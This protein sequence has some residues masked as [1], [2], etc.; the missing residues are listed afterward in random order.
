MP[1]VSYLPDPIYNDML[2]SERRPVTPFE[3]ARLVLLCLLA[4]A[5]SMLVG[6]FLAA[7]FVFRL[8]A[9]A[10]RAASRR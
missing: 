1:L 6:S 3:A 5:F 10:Y 2:E 7:R 8:P 4:L 9:A